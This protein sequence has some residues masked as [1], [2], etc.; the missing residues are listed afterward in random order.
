MH[1]DPPQTD[2]SRDPILDGRDSLRLVKLRLA[3]T[4]ITVAILPIA[5]VSPLVR[6]AAEEA[7][8]AHHQ[9]LE[10][11]A[12]QVTT[13]F[14]REVHGV[15]AMSADLLADPRVVAASAAGATGATRAAASSRLGDL[16][17][18]D[19]GAVIGVTLRDDGGVRAAYGAPLDPAMLPGAD[20]VPGLF[21]VTVGGAESSS[22]VVV[23][24]PAGANGHHLQLVTVMSLP[25]LL[26]W[27][28][29]PVKIPGQTI[30]LIDDL[31]SNVATY[32]SAFDPTALP[33]QFLDIATEA[34]HDSDGH[35]AVGLDELPGWTAVVS[36]PIPLAAL[37][38]AAIGALAALIALLAGF[39]LWMARQI[40]RPAAQLEASRS[41][42]REL[43]E[44]AREAALRDNLT[45]LGNH[46]AF[47]EAVARMVEGSR[48]YGTV[49]S[50][51]LLDID[52]FKRINDTRG[53]A[54]G[55]QLLA[56][57]GELIRVTLRHTDAG[58]RVGGDEFALLLPHT[59]A[60]GAIGMAKRLLGRGLEDR[61]SGSFRGPISFSAGVTSCPEFAS[62]RLELTAQADAALYRG[63]RAG[64][65]VV[66]VYDPDKD[67][68]HVDEGMRAELSSAI[69]AVIE[70]GWLTPVYQPIIDLA[71]GN[72]TGY[73]GLVRVPKESTFAHTGA[74][75]DAA[76]AAG[77]VQD[78]DRA[79]LE[80]V[81]RGAVAVS[82]NLD[83]N[84]NVSPRSLESPE[85]NATVFLAILNRHN[86]RPGRVVLELTE[87]EAIRDPE[88]L[89][90]AMQAVQRAG[91]RIAADDVG[92][93]NAGLRLLSQFKF[94]VVKIDL[95]LVHGAR[96]DQTLSVLTSLVQMADRWGALTIAE[97][98][99]TPA[100][101]RTIRRLGISAAQGY[102][103]GRPGPER[104]IA[105]VDIE[106]LE[107][108]EAD[109]AP[110]P[111]DLLTL[112]ASAPRTLPPTSSG[113]FATVK[114][115]SLAL[116]KGPKT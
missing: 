48:R 65:T 109:D 67:H 103:L 55:D 26:N 7:R 85:F 79:A 102:L 94:D 87:R 113:V 100:Q 43:Y 69:S 15:Q 8:V 71:T 107:S 66:T 83:L 74:L 11:E 10:S 54:V 75:F 97:G 44:S 105:W 114:G 53:H 72:V 104:D 28:A 115:R 57:V 22:L 96:E 93:G 112:A 64:R 17:R 33:G 58:F 46:R 13:T 35:A 92:A 78:L 81:L 91:V 14:D 18:R 111:Q 34:A 82:E 52:E 6:A 68:G 12:S 5:A 45:G 76:E 16:M 19:S 9:R 20:P 73:E 30:G 4:L 27:S 95:S 63:K 41:R 106:A 49:F 1:P 80:V 108:R 2:V 3:L 84:V 40:L 47:Q 29:P 42:L 89:R 86:V 70:A 98:V 110:M 36:A 88:R 116:R 37:P 51:V 99:E 32:R 101:L 59:D 31:G 39:T 21:A 25:A 24:F 38:V 90:T 60:G 50:L 23:T 56:Q 61:G 77:R 62:T